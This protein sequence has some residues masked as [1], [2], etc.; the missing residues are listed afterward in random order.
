MVECSK[1]KQYSENILG[2]MRE[3]LQIKARKS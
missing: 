1:Y 3:K 2:K